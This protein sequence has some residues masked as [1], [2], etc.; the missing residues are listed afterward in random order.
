MPADRREHCTIVLDA[1]EKASTHSVLFQAGDGKRKIT[2]KACVFSLAR[3]ERLYFLDLITRGDLPDEL[4]PDKK[5]EPPPPEPEPVPIA[6]K[7]VPENSPREASQ[8][9]S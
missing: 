2:W 7:E 1:L 6:E 9:R 3:S 8:P 5:P 4:N